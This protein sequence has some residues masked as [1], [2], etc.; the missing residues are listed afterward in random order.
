M[1]ADTDPMRDAIARI[2]T[3]LQSEYVR[4]VTADLI[5]LYAEVSG[6]FHPI[7]VDADYAAATSYGK[8]I[9]HGAML[10]GFMSTASTIL[11]ERIEEDIG[12][13]NVSLGYDRV[14]LIAPVF[15]GDRITTRISIESLQPERYRVICEEICL[16]QDGETVAVAQHVMRF[17]ESDAN[18]AR[19]PAAK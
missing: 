14:R 19:Q 3:S 17:I 7:H 11:S 4:D 9:A 6:D 13:P 5:R 8:P 18:G 12:Y 2:D 10:L 15:A 16:N 1:S